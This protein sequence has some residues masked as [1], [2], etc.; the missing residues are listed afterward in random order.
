MRRRTVRGWA[1]ASLCALAFAAAPA[2]SAAP[3]LDAP[4]ELLDPQ[5][6]FRIST[7]ALGGQRVEVEFRIAEGYYLY[8]DRFRFATESGE[9][10]AEVEIPRGKAKEDPS[11]G[12]TE[13]F[14]DQV[15]IRLTVSAKDA[16][17]GSVSLKV[18]SQ[19]CA[20]GRV[21]YAP[22][23]QVVKVRLPG[24]ASNRDGR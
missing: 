2:A 24:A 10:L 12:K 16:A 15:R 21:C 7:R 9:P 23:E 1:V 4:G 14:R 19:G 11:F 13:T 20:E 18:T 22:L 3:W 8:R 17:K 6:A 5:K